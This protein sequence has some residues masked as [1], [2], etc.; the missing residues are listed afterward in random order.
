MLLQVQYNNESS[1]YPQETGGGRLSWHLT[2]HT[3]NGIWLSC[4]S[5]HQCPHLTPLHCGLNV[6]TTAPNVTPLFL[7]LLLDFPGYVRINIFHVEM[8]LNRNRGVAVNGTR[9]LKGKKVLVGGNFELN[10][11]DGFIKSPQFA[12]LAVCCGKTDPAFATLV[13]DL[14]TK[15][16][17]LVTELADTKSDL[18]NTKIELSR[19]NAEL[20][21]AQ[22]KLKLDVVAAVAEIEQELKDECVLGVTSCQAGEYIKTPCSKTTTQTCAACFSGTFSVDGS[23]RTCAKHTVCSPGASVT[24]KPS[25]AADTTCTNCP[26]GQFSKTDNAAECTPCT[27]ACKQGDAM[28]AKCTTVADIVCVAPLFAFTE[29]GFVSSSS[30]GHGGG[31]TTWAG[32]KETKLANQYL[33]EVW[34][35]KYFTVK[36]GVQSWTVPQDGN[37]RLTAAGAAG[38]GVTNGH[39]Q[40]A[41]GESGRVCYDT[42]AF[43]KGDVLTIV[44]GQMGQTAK[45]GG[46]GG[47]ATWAKLNHHLFSS[48]NTVLIVGGGGGG[49]GYYKLGQA[50]QD[51]LGKETTGGSAGDGGGGGG[52]AGLTTNGVTSGDESCGGGGKQPFNWP[53]P[54]LGGTSFAPS[55]A[56]GRGGFGGGGG[57]GGGKAANAGGGGGGYQGG[58]GGSGLGPGSSYGSKGGSSYSHPTLGSGTTKYDGYRNHDGYLKVTKV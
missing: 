8:A 5:I 16:D 22:T 50:G 11:E 35:E 57:A 7:F 34:W 27:A 51:Y 24:Q 29:F 47:G 26:D 43:K 1:P 37:Y 6:A 31:T 13:N 40:R 17:A 3:P 14:V 20:S 36:D 42:F 52:G 33:G 25:L 38:G 56:N 4:R 9:I 48:S 30:N 2:R 46:G 12:Q 28:S 10:P 32:P 39:A 55:T 15:V 45:H 53:N 18:S 23:Q 21:E 44:I 58:K 49:D 54:A 19:A 41:T